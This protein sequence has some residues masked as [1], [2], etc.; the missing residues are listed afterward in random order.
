MVSINAVDLFCGVGGLTCGLQQAGINVVAGY[1]IDAASKYPY[2]KNNKAQFIL[3]DVVDIQP[4]EI[5][6]LYPKETQVKVLMGCAP[7]QPFSSYNR[8]ERDNPL[9]VEKMLLLDQF[10]KQIR[11]VTP[12]I[13]SMENVPQMAKE[14]VFETFLKTLSEL[15]YSVDWKIVFA[16]DYGVPQ[17]RRRL[18]LLASR[19]G[20][21]SLLSPE[22]LGG[23]KKQNLRDIISDLPRLAAGQTDPQ[24]NL[25]RARALTDI[26]L[27]RIRK[28]K[29]GGTWKDWPEELLPNAYRRESGQTYKSVYGRMSWDKPASTMTT[30]FIGYGSGRFGHPEQD[31]A[32]SLREGALI[33]TF[34]KDYLFVDPTIEDHYSMNKVALQIGNAVPPKLGEAI[35]KS[36]LAHIETLTNEG[37]S[38]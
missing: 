7:C 36:I 13:V 6:N 34:P 11:L 33:Q 12:D 26:N 9:R 37:I 38:Q 21:I 27:K 2:E 14:P 35:G 5:T 24:D 23:N 25:H 32:I 30:Q 10:G 20:A 22:E 8:M 3:K 19:H 28:S 29:P 1:D 4:Q 16:P 17:R 15:G 31:R 18:I